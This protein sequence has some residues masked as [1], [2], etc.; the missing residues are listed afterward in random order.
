MDKTIF[1][2]VLL[3]GQE[4]I[5]KQLKLPPHVHQVPVVPT[6][7]VYKVLYKALDLLPFV[8][9]ILVGPVVSV[10]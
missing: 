10:M 5:V 4:E 1:V 8:I 6:V 2:H 9:V 7:N 3:V